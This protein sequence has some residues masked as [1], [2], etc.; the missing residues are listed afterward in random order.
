MILTPEQIERDLNKEAAEFLYA[1]WQEYVQCD[2]HISEDTE[3]EWRMIVHPR[4][5]KMASLG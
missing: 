2:G 4:P 1:L 3:R 5:V